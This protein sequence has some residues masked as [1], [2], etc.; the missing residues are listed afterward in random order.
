MANHFI[1]RLPLLAKLSLIGL[2]PLCFLVYLTLQVYREKTAKLALFDDYKSF[3][4][5]SAQINHLIDALQEE[6]KYSFDYAMTRQMHTELLLQ[7]PRTDSL[8][9]ALSKSSD[10]ALEAFTGY[11]N[12]G[13]LHEIRS[14]IDSFSIQPSGVMHYYSNTVFRLNTLNTLPPGN[15]PFL[16]PVYRD[17]MAQKILS[18]MITYLGIIRSNIYNVLYTRKYMVETLFG[19]VGTHDVYQSYE[20]EFLVKAA[21]DVRTRYNELRVASPLAPTTAYID[22]LFKRFTFDSSYTAAAWWQVSDKGVAS[23]RAFQ[24]TIWQR[25][26]KDVQTIYEQESQSRTRTLVLLLISLASVVLVA[27]YIVYVV[28][29]SLLRLQRAAERIAR[30]ETSVSVPAES[31]DA[32]G[33]L[34]HSISSIDKNNQTLSGAAASI[35]KGDFGVHIEP[36]SDQDELAFALI[37]MKQDLSAYNEK[38]EQLVQHRTEEL[39]RSNEDLQRFAHVASHDLKEPLRKISTF[40]SILAEEQ[41]DVLSERG[42]VYLQK[43][44]DASR[45]MVQMIEGVLAYSTLTATEHPF[46]SVDLNHVLEN[47]ESDLELAIVQKEAR[48]ERALLPRIQGIPMLIQQLFYNLVNNALKFSKPGVAPIITIKADAA[49]QVAG[50]GVLM[51]HITVSDNGIGF[52]PE[53]AEKMFTFFSRLHPRDQYEGTGLGLAL[54]KKIVQRHGGSIYATGAEGEGAMF[55]LL[56]PAR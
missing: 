54:C 22:T 13:R 45:R 50:S 53:H 44:G 27:A 38:M 37:R 4:A 33:S 40:S 56:L 24:S 7:R 3:I 9:L 42:K 48:I 32:I 41:K 29:Q 15:S 17:L 12:L 19:T 10:P 31:Q 46:E 11:T 35:G 49:A 18:E 47:V 5:E 20:K 34:A 6:R 1:R 26:D 2:I 43:I 52:N 23:L 51:V 16:Q 25:L 55:H 21:P 39:A 36:R 8:I 14:Q 30:G 28:N